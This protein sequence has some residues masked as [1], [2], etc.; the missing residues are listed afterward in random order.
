MLQNL[1]YEM[2]LTT[3]ENGALAHK[4]TDNACL[5]LFGLIGALRWETEERITDLFLRAFAENRDDALRIMFYARDVHG[6]Q[7]ERRVF[8][9]MLHWLAVHEPESVHKNLHLIPEY[10]RFD[11]CLVLLDT[12]CEPT[13]VGMLRAQL[14]ADLAGMADGQHVSLMAK[15]L[16]SVN[17]SSESTR[18]QAKRLCRLLHLSEKEYRRTLSALRSYLQVLEPMLCRKDYSFAY[19]NLPSKALYLHR[20]AF[21]KRDGKRYEEYL[22]NVENGEIRMK[23]KSLYPYEVVR[24]CIGY[25]NKLHE[26]TDRERRILDLTWKSLPDYT[27]DRNAIAVVDGSGSMYWNENLPPIAVAVSLGIYFAERSRGAFRNHF[28]TFSNEPRLVKIKG[29]DILEKVRYCMNYNEVD[30]TNLERVFQLIL[31]TAVYNHLPQE[32]LPEVVYIISDM[33][34]NEGCSGVRDTLFHRM[35]EAYGH[36]GYRLPTIVYWNVESRNTQFPVQKDEHGTVLVSGCSPGIFKM[37]IRQEDTPDGFMRRVL[38]SER[39]CGITA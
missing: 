23:T 11:D 31:N 12:P 39:Y 28:I 16:P 8:R 14:D 20:Q 27:D 36:Y 22:K 33:E 30:S 6:G 5:D 29:K 24:S 34:F 35:Q 18:M 25:F 2:N 37:A 19:E 9:I 26:G 21:Q 38:D 10:G 32:E 13:L 15:W 17:T 4:S 1:K 7:G 3:T